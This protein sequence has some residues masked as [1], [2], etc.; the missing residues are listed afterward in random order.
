MKRS[1]LFLVSLLVVTTMVAAPVSQQRAMQV[2]Q[3]FIP[4]PDGQ[5]Q[6]PGLREEAQ[7]A[8]IVYTHP[9]PKSGRPAFYVVNVGGSFVIVS[10]D[11][12]AHQVLGYNLGKS[13]PVAANGEIQLPPQVKGFFD[14]LAAQ[15]EAAIEAN[16]NH[17][18][19]ADWSQ[20]QSAA[21]RR[22]M[23]SEMP[24]S[25]GPLLTTTW[26]QGPY[27][28]SLCPEDQQGPNG[29]VWAGCLA[30][31]MAQLIKY[32]GNQTHGKGAHNYYNQ[33]YGELSVNFDTTTYDFA[34]MPDYLTEESSPIEVDA[35]AKLMY[36]CG[37]SLDMMYGAA[38]SGAYIADM[39]SAL[40]NHFGFSKNMG[41]V[42]SFYY[43]N[44]DWSAMLRSNISRFQPIIYSSTHVYPCGDGWGNEGHSYLLDG[45][46]SEGF[47]HFNFGWNG[48]GDGWYS[49]RAIEPT[50]QNFTNNQ[51]AI[52]EILPDNVSNI[53]LGHG[54]QQFGKSRFEVSEAFHF[55]DALS[56]NEYKTTYSDS[57]SD[58]I[59]FVSDDTS[60]QLVL[61][62]I[63]YQ[64]GE[65]SIYDGE[66]TDFLLRQLSIEN[67]NNDLSPVVSS[68][69]A[70]TLVFSGS[71]PGKA[72]HFY[73]DKEGPCRMVSELTAIVDS[74]NIHLSWEENGTTTHWRVEYGK[75]GFLP[76]SG[77]ILVVDSNNITI[78]EIDKDSVYEIRIQPDC[79]SLNNDV[80]N[81]IIVNEKEMAY[82]IDIVTSQPEGYMEDSL[83]NVEI[84]SAE[85]LA[86]F[87]K[88]SQNNKWDYFMGRKATLTADID[89]KGYV[90][91]GLCSFYG[92]FDGNGHIISNMYCVE[93]SYNCALFR[94]MKD[95][96]VKNVS[97]VN[98][99][100]RSTESF[101]IAGGIV[102]EAISDTIINCFVSG[103]IE[104]H[105]AGPIVAY[106]DRH[107][108]M[109]INC[110]SNCNIFGHNIGG[111]IVGRGSQ[112]SVGM[113]ETYPLIIENCYSASSTT[114]DSW[115]SGTILG[116][117]DFAIL[118][119]CY[120]YEKRQ[121]AAKVLTGGGQESFLTNSTWFNRIDSDFFLIEPIFFE[122][123]SLYY[124]N[125][126]DALNAGV[127]KYNVE[128]LRL[129]VDD[130][131]GINE[132]MP[133]LGPEYIVS[134]PNIKNLTARNVI[135]QDGQY[136]VE[137]SW[138]E[139]GEAATWEV[140]LLI[141][142]IG[143][144]GP[145]SLQPNLKDML[146]TL[147]VM[148][149]FQQQ[150]VWHG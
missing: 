40:I 29:H 120:G 2:A 34:H 69:P 140:R 123:D 113:G 45:Y 105:S 36:H 38:A 37:V 71:L 32:W 110:A 148:S 31:A 124:T 101:G 46:N 122:S 91:R 103:T 16:P 135:G 117:G 50:G 119:N 61:D 93:D 76:G 114:H 20:P 137:L 28:N 78:P 126:K 8:G 51:E 85:G 1:V 41:L 65:I 134:C 83:G 108:N 121:M 56:L 116:Y 150:K 109:I 104:G 47:F 125:L 70:L 130:T 17:T 42:H 33:Y 79:D 106:S 75:K 96:I 145:K 107:A 139:M 92:T 136:G 128:G 100:S 49:L 80:V 3:Q 98:I 59:T 21:P 89:L 7:P 67:L 30:T 99:Y 94:R 6:A 13:W 60:K 97:L 118:D 18:P 138:T 81:S 95:A 77:T 111:G 87:S 141:I 147:L 66:S 129:W 26:G 58:T 73:I 82:W 90:W 52:V 88:E 19:D 133:I 84:S 44:E 132:G 72:I 35:V 131:L 142:L 54:V 14:D 4:V 24:D 43:S 9:M 57:Y 115:G 112:M 68:Q 74:T 127:R 22:R 5:A 146:L 11:D 10:A 27:Y 39:Y 25:V 53:L 149:P 62:V 12:V 55:Y 143:C 102:G 15:M 64:S 144:T 63:N 86:W 48:G 23:I